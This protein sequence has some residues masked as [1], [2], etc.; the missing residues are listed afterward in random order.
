MQYNARSS[1]K[2]FVALETEIRILY[3]VAYDDHLHIKEWYDRTEEASRK[4]RE[5]RNVKR[6]LSELMIVSEDINDNFETLKISDFFKLVYFLIGYHEELYNKIDDSHT[7][8]SLISKN[9]GYSF[10]STSG[11]LINRY[12]ESQKSNKVG[13]NNQRIEMCV[14]YIAVFISR[15]LYSPYLKAQQTNSQTQIP[16]DLPISK[17]KIYNMSNKQISTEK[18]WF[19]LVLERVLKDNNHRNIPQDNYDQILNLAY[20]NFVNMLSIGSYLKSEVYKEKWKIMRPSF[21]EICEAGWTTKT[22]MCRY[23]EGPVT[24]LDFPFET[25]E[26]KETHLLL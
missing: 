23:F 16:L 13:N 15:L 24:S 8:I 18:T 3:K 19:M 17:L 10:N 20:Q 12:E 5:N 26:P 11:Y 6:L 14:F 2:K 1:L 9:K 4:W 21:F 22:L 7:L 25:L